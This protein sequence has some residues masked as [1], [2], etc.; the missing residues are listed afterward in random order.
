[1]KKQCLQEI[2][3]SRIIAIVRGI[4]CHQIIDLAEAL[5]QG[6]ITCMEITFDQSAADF[7]DTLAS[8]E[9]IRTRFEG[10]IFVG[11][12][13]VM[14]GE[15][16]ELAIEA[17]A[18]YIISP[19]VDEAVIR[20]TKELDK[21]SIPGAMTPTEVAAAASYG[22]DLVK[23]FPAGMLGPDYI[24]ALKGPLNHIPLTAVGGISPE[25]CAAFIRAGAVGVGCGGKLV[26]PNLVEEKRFDIIASIAG[27]YTAALADCQT[28]YAYGE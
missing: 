21:L 6:G 10:K 4:P 2:K 8:I 11:A 28:G 23:L 14:T 1:M 13:T 24:K 22:A 18:E 17:G 16:A 26:S 20:R 7:Q 15:Q 3:K 19:N 27:K 5:H 25:N 12:G 9:R